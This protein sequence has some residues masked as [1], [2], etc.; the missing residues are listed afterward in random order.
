MTHSEKCKS[1]GLK[2]LADYIDENH[3]GNKAEFARKENVTRQLV[4]QWI[5]Q[6][7]IVVGSKLCSVRRDLARD[8]S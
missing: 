6:G 8:G 2:S 3:A 7:Y 4:N 5:N 1:A